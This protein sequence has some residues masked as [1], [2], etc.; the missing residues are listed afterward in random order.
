LIKTPFIKLLEHRFLQIFRKLWTGYSIQSFP[1]L[2]AVFETNKD[3][4][5]TQIE[6]G[7]ALNDIISRV[8]KVIGTLELPKACRVYLIQQMADIEH[9]LSVGTSDKIQLSAL[10]GAFKVAMDM[11]ESQSLNR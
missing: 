2:T 7:I 11:T 3:I 5:A 1:K 8:F 9:N 10:V 6:K 4:R